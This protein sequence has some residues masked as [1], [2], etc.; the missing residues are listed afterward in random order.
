MKA[1]LCVV[2]VNLGNTLNHPPLFDVS[3]VPPYIHTSPMKSNRASGETGSRNNH[4]QLILRALLPVTHK[5][6]YMGM[7]KTR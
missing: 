5:F 7:L 4:L 3:T 1:T 6:N 2:H